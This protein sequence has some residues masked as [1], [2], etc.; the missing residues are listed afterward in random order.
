MIVFYNY[1]LTQFEDKN[2]GLHIFQMNLN[3]IFV[4]LYTII[5][6]HQ[7]LLSFF[8]TPSRTYDPRDPQELLLHM[9]SGIK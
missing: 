1:F 5:Y 2:L 7:Q 8:F 4:Y 6:G 9:S 3:I